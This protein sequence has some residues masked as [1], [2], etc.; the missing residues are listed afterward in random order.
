MVSL[1][2]DYSCLYDTDPCGG[3]SK[4][5]CCMTGKNPHPYCGYN[6]DLG[7]HN[8]NHYVFYQSPLFYLMT[9]PI[10]DLNCP[11]RDAHATPFGDSYQNEGMPDLWSLLVLP[12]C[13]LFCHFQG[14]QVVQA[15]FQPL[16]S[17]QSRHLP[18]QLR[19]SPPLL[20]WQS[21][22]YWLPPLPSQDHWLQKESSDWRWV[23][24]SWPGLW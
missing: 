4:G 12:D 16:G 24:F 23:P 14:A 19:Y 13:Y 15:A 22:H 5:L 10:A 8:G 18:L 11:S 6:M 7:G 1:A 2:T 20:G 21:H 3:H 17:I 9:V